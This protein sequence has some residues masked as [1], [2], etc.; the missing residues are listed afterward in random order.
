MHDGKLKSELNLNVKNVAVG[1]RKVI[2]K[3]KRKQF[4]KNEMKKSQKMLK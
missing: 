3:C 2:E 1:E 4:C